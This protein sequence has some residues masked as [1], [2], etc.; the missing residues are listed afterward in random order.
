MAEEK[1]RNRKRAFE[2]VL[3][4][5]I[6]PAE[7]DDQVA[8][9]DTM[10]FIHSARGM[11][12]ACLLFSIVV[13]SAFVYFHIS[14]PASLID[15]AMFAILA[16]FISLG[17]R[18]AMIAAMLLWTLEKGS[19]IVEGVSGAH[20]NVV[21]QIIWWCIYMHAFYLTFRVEQKRKSLAR[22]ATV[23]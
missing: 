4:W 23:A 7:L 2:W 5:K 22:A 13:T 20:T 18:W 19:V 17:H 12:V 1:K 21:V 11:S 9:Y 8:R 14:D 15:A 16:L 3:W 6:N 10:G